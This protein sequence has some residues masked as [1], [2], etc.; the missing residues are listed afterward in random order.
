MLFPVCVLA[1]NIAIFRKW[2]VGF[3]RFPRLSPGKTLLLSDAI[4]IVSQL[5]GV[6]SGLAAFHFH[7]H[8]ILLNL[9]FGFVSLAMCACVCVSA[10]I[11]FMVKFF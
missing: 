8:F 6:G 4:T 7:F 2:F 10:L 1:G 11:K 3:S 5:S 9:I